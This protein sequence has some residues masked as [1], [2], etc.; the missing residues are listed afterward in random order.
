[1]RFARHL[2]WRAVE[3]IRR[4]RVLWKLPYHVP[5]AL[6]DKVG[7]GPCSGAAT[8]LIYPSLEWRILAT[9]AS[10][11]AL[12]A[13]QCIFTDWLV[14]LLKIPLFKILLCKFPLPKMQL[15]C[16]RPESDNEFG[17]VGNLIRI[18]P[19]K[20]IPNRSAY[21]AGRFSSHRT[22]LFLQELHPVRLRMWCRLCRRACT[23]CRTCVSC[24]SSLFGLSVCVCVRVLVSA[25]VSPMRLFPGDDHDLVR[26][27]S[28]NPHWSHTISFPSKSRSPRKEEPRD[29]ELSSVWIFSRAQGLGMYFNF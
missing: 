21:Q 24:M 8:C 13:T 27:G 6:S 10:D 29:S 7:S 3:W 20:E 25:P 18:W 4:S 16:V 22:C 1:V 12:G 23:G 9:G 15:A 2:E 28:C 5:G 19:Q 17:L 11:K 26:N 14:P